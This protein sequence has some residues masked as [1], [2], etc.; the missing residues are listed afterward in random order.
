MPTIQS[1][2]AHEILDSRGN[3]TVEA[4]MILS[5][6]IRA[7][8][9]V[10]S[11]AST[12]TRE[13]CELRDKDLKRY[14]GKGVLK[15][16]DH[17][18]TIIAPALKGQDVTAQAS[19]DQTL[20]VLDDT[21]N[22]THLGA[23]ALL[24]VSLAAAR[25]GSIAKS[26]PLYRY[27]ATSQVL[28][29]PIPMMNI[30]NG[31]AHA[32]NGL[33]IQEFMIIPSG[34]PNFAE[35]LRYGAEV[36]HALKAK[37]SEAGLSTSVGDEGGF[38]PKLKGHEHAIHLI[39]EA[40]EAAGFRVGQ[41]IKLALDAASSEFYHD[42]Q[43]V[44]QTEN[45]KF[46]QEAMVDYW[47]NLVNQYPISSIEDGMAEQDWEGWRLLTERLGQ[48]IQL[49]G[50]DLFVTNTKILQEGIAQ[51]IA[52]AILIKPNQIGTLTETLAAI[53]LAQ[54]AKYGTVISHRSGETEDTFIADLAVATHAGQIKTGSLCR[55]DRV[56]KYNRLL[57][58]EC[59][60]I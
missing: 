47:E 58:I 23:N 31:G 6:G 2:F 3:P 59:E 26:L 51:G 33:D 15:A 19:I 18:N 22:K 10:P 20:I 7:S 16:C 52:N 35:S 53:K 14:G 9:S 28:T 39:I 50:D 60:L 8:A 30:L 25:A 27:L 40:I 17:I 4:E 1:I 34:A 13:A 55:T 44:L 46:K 32:D 54:D 29:L 36:F 37:L 41:D 49:V 45:R 21:P 56:A 38:A 42:N 5:N 57:R 48:R 11:G 24:A 43:Y 12:G